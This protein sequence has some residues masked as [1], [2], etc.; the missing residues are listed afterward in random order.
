M[1][2]NGGPLRDLLCGR[3]ALDV[4]GASA[5]ASDAEKVEAPRHA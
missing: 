3:T 1:K 5:A 4:D 2:A